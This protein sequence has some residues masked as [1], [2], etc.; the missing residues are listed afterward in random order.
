MRSFRIPA[1]IAAVM[2]TLAF[3]I[4]Q[5]VL[6]AE[7][8]VALSAEDLVLEQDSLLPEDG[9]L[10]SGQDSLL[11]EDDSLLSGQDS[12][13]TEDAD[14]ASGEEDALN[15]AKVESITI[16]N[17][18]EKMIVGKKFKLKAKVRPKKP[19]G[20][21]IT[22]KSSDNSIATEDKNGKVKAVGSGIVRIT[23]KCGGKRTSCK[24]K[25]NIKGVI[26]II[27]DDGRKEFRK[28]LLPIMKEKNISISTAIVP[29]WVGT[30]RRMTWDEIAKCKKG[31]A[32]ILCHTLRHHDVDHTLGM[33]EKEIRKEYEKA[34]RILERHGYFTDI[35]VYSHCTG[36]I[37]KARKAASKVFGCGMVHDFRH[38]NT[39]DTDLYFLNR[40]LIEGPIAERPWEM[41]EYVDKVK[42][43]G[44]WMIWELHCAIDRVDDTALDNLRDA[45][46]YAKK[47]GVEIVTAQEGYE[48][49]T[50]K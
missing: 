48:R 46:D 33:T 28:K 25:V 26:T 41:K 18:P 36:E 50:N 9:S 38:I 37:K 12:L 11:P 8:P 5:T 29:K 27:D 49:F 34:K 22:W 17:N 30:K 6:A 45:I 42:K 2:L 3:V 10:L 13:S 47:Q 4:P 32:E 19:K 44:G 43:E 35:L 14:T 1:R 21:K 39:V 20:Q 23:A 16:T 31:G 24:I 40:Y 15:G 7:E